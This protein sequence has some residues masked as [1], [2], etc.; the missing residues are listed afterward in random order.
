MPFMAQPSE[1]GRKLSAFDTQPQEARKRLTLEDV[2]KFARPDFIERI[3]EIFYQQHIIPQG[4]RLVFEKPLKEHERDGKI[5][6]AKY[7]HER[8]YGK[9]AALVS[10]L[11]VDLD[12]EEVAVVGSEPEKSTLP[13]LHMHPDTV[14]DVTEEYYWVD[15]DASLF[16]DGVEH[17][18]NQENPFVSVKPEVVHKLVTKNYSISVIIMKNVADLPQ[19]QRHISVEE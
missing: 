17:K 10:I 2:A 16:M 13:H 6:G 1:A 18:L 5:S 3:H 11:V 4:E 12:G 7:G 15:G 14:T 19:D 8:D 9:H